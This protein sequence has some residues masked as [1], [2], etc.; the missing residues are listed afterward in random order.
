[1]ST[2]S[3]SLQVSFFMGRFDSPLGNPLTALVLEF[4][5]WNSELRLRRAALFVV[6][7]A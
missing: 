4:E 1:V 2:L 5:I 7:L 3:I 6:N